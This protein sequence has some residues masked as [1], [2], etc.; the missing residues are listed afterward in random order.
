[1][2]Q[3][4]HLVEQTGKPVA[5]G[6]GGGVWLRSETCE[7]FLLLHQSSLGGPTMQHLIGC[8][9]RRP[10]MQRTVSRETGGGRLPFRAC[11]SR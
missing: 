11:R 2:V 6:Q 3:W 7:A 5:F 4:T 1:M 9:A 8:I 10:W